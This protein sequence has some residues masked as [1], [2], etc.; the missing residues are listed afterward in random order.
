MA[1]DPAMDWDG[2]DVMSLMFER[3]MAMAWVKRT[4]GLAR[5]KYRGD[6]PSFEVAL[7]SMRGR[8]P[9][10]DMSAQ[11]V[12]PESHKIILALLATNEPST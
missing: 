11:A 3:T 5:K 2:Y 4:R 10:V 9:R 1:H 7:R 6:C 8:K 12:T